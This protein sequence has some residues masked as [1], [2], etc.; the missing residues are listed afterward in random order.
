MDAAVM[1]IMPH[2]GKGFMILDLRLVDCRP[3]SG[4]TKRRF[5]AGSCSLARHPADMAAVSFVIPSHD[6]RGTRLG[7][8]IQRGVPN[9]FRPW[10]S[11]LGAELSHLKLRQNS[12]QTKVRSRRTT[13]TVIAPPPRR[14]NLHWKHRVQGEA[15][16]L[17]KGSRIAGIRFR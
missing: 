7:R 3:N 11:P 2:F 6:V 15:S 17:E 16:C 9:P 10:S 4:R 8:D 14:A 1:S 12:D 5:A 13:R